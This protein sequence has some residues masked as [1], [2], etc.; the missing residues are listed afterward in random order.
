MLFRI[1]DVALAEGAAETLMRVALSLMHKN[2]GRLLACTELDEVMQLLLSRGIWDCYHY[3]ADQFV[4]DFVSL[5]DVVTRE[6]LQALELAFGE[7]QQQM[8]AVVGGSAASSSPSNPNSSTI[9][10]SANAATRT[11][12]VTTAASRFLGRLW[13]SSN[14]T[15]GGAN[16]II[17]TNTASSTILSSTTST[18]TSLSTPR[19]AH[20]LSP[21]LNPPPHSSTSSLSR[22]LSMLRRSA[23][24]QSLASTLNSMEAGSAVSLFSAAST[25]ATTVSRD[26]SSNTSDYSSP[27]QTNKY[28]NNTGGGAV[29]GRGGNNGN[30]VGNS[31]SRYL[32]SQI[33]D[34]L[35]ALSEL[36]RNH[37]LLASQLQRE[38]EEREEDGKAVRALVDG[39]RK[40]KTESESSKATSSTIK[41]TSTVG[42]RVQ[43]IDSS[44]VSRTATPSSKPAA[45]AADL[46]GSEELSKLLEA[47]EQRFGVG[48]SDASS[49]ASGGNGGLSSS[50]QHTRAELHD[51]LS[52]ARDQLVTESSRATDLSRR[53]TEAEQEAASL[54]E[55]LRE[56]HNHVR[57]LHSDKQR[58][59]RQIH[60]MRAR[61]SA[62]G[63]GSGG[64]AGTDG[65]EWFS[66]VAASMTK[67]PV[68]SAGGLREFKLGRSKS[69]PTSQAVGVTSSVGAMSAALSRRT[70]SLIRGGNDGGP[71]FLNLAASTAPPANEHEALLLELVQAKTAEA[72]AR[73]EAE[74]AKAKLESLRRQYGLTSAAAAD[75]NHHQSQMLSSTAASAAQAAMGVLG[76]FTGSV[77]EAGAAGVAADKGATTNTVAASAGQFAPQS[78]VATTASS[79]TAS[80]AA[81]VSSFWGGWR[82]G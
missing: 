56:S 15:S 22:P 65:T 69:T 10:A 50:Q 67:G 34:L 19:T 27:T 40:K 81:A 60:D 9:I 46:L 82:K 48:S 41:A 62:D 38:K 52:R 43:L 77:T 75:N 59:E 4:Q 63:S 2:E 32:H 1:Y 44:N 71:S 31:D 29:A 72:V 70:S 80:A 66:S 79:A 47:V 76:R 45:T 8:Q 5:S 25:D 36:Q 42:S 16:S 30:G 61:A 23:S 35:T 68:P 51:E 18:I 37:L 33:E 3:N 20:N 74:E 26:S 17:T 21:G 57:T 6:S 24:K 13:S 28:N 7:Q 64:G 49:S 14:S 73:Q 11:S 58:L 55:Q 12:E 78:S 39:L 54:R 53:V